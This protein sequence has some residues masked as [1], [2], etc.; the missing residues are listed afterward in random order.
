MQPSAFRSDNNKKISADVG[1]FLVKD[2][3]I[4]YNRSD[5]KN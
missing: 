2:H 4:I 1:I 5:L 3:K